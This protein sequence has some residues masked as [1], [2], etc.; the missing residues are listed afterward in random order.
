MGYL[1]RRLSKAVISESVLQETMGRLDDL[2]M[3]DLDIDHMHQA[4]KAELAQRPD[5]QQQL[6]TLN[7][8]DDDL[9]SI[10]KGIAP[11]LRKEKK[12]RLKGGGA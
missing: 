2:T 4:L 10:I 3:A 8:D 11:K 9:R 5:F 7:L 12:R 1:L 6:E